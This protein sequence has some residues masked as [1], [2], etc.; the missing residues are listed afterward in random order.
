LGFYFI[1][2]P[3]ATRASILLLAEMLLAE[4]FGRLDTRMC[5]LASMLARILL[6][7]YLM[8][9]ASILPMLASILTR[10]DHWMFGHLAA[11]SDSFTCFAVLM[12]ARMLAC[13]YVRLLRY[14]VAC[15]TIGRFVA[16]MLTWIFL[17]ALAS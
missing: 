5:L 7:A 14:S 13:S 2:L 6:L 8:L 15:W 16:S 10:F 4:I 3:A 9:I 17:L 1:W 11:R 12:L